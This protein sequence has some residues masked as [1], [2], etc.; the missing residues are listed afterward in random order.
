M[1]LSVIHDGP[2]RVKYKRGAGGRWKEILGFRRG[3]ADAEC[4]PSIPTMSGLGPP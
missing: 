2:A 4:G 3:N 1:V